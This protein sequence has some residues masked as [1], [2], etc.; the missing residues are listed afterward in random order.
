MNKL[1][2][3]L[4]SLSPEMREYICEKLAN[5]EDD[6]LVSLSNTFEP[7][8]SL[9]RKPKHPDSDEWFVVPEYLGSALSHSKTP[10]GEGMRMIVWQTLVFAEVEARRLGNP[11]FWSREEIDLDRQ[12][13]VQLALKGQSLREAREYY[14][15]EEDVV[16]DPMDNFVD[17]DEPADADGPQEILMSPEELD[18]LER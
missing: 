8:P 2:E 17:I 7:F 4:N 15:P 11:E 5:I 18:Q 9:R 12:N 13:Y 6:D 3:I 14:D 10:I 1:D 16:S